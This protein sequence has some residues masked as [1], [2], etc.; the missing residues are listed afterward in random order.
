MKDY[1]SVLGIEREA[2]EDDIKKAF[3][4]LAQ[5]YHPDKQGGDDAKFKEVSEA[6]SILS[7][8]D[9][10]AQYDGGGQGGGNPFGAGFDFSQFQ[11]GFQSG[12][13][14]FGDIFSEMFGGGM[15]RERRGRDLSIDLELSFSESIF[16]VERKMLLHKIAVCDTCEGNGAEKDSGT[17]TC[18]ACN[19]RGQIHE[20]R[21]TF[22]GSVT[23]QRECDT[24]AGKGKVPKKPCKG[25]KGLGVARKQEEVSIRVPAGISDGEM[26]RLTKMGEAIPGGVAGDLYVKIHVKRD[27]RF[28]REGST[29]VTQHTVSISDALLGAEQDIV[30]LDGKE[31]ITVPAGT[32][33]GDTIRVKGKGVP[34]SASNRGDLIVKVSI[35][36]PKKLSRQQQKLVE[37]L[38]EQ[39]L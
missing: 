18:K 28:A 7:N 13:F 6:Y 27:A 15:K 11:Q 25:C 9:K 30:S 5:K 23:T 3:R 17:D 35:T 37:Q 31:T 4:K 20:S 29:L 2:S 16:G 14:D 24:C 1:Y 8:K 39:G 33:H 38:K 34:T 19:G 21:N 32:N 36:I 10:R 22:L 26:I 12:N